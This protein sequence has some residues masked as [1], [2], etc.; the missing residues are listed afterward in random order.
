M[1]SKCFDEND[2]IV[3]TRELEMNFTSAMTYSIRPGWYYTL[4]DTENIP[5]KYINIKQRILNPDFVPSKK[6]CRKSGKGNDRQYQE[7]TLN[8][9][10]LCP[11]RFVEN[12]DTSRIPEK[13]LETECICKNPVNSRRK[14]NLICST[15]IE[16]ISVY[17]KVSENN[18]EP[19]YTRS[20]EPRS[21]ACVGSSLP[22]AQRKYITQTKMA[23]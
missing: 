17:R 18:G 9:L 13:I 14:D 1:A 22:R 20:W 21:V 11:W 3:R 15:V 23:L 2:D 19:V 6:I 16:Y 12:I 5:S 4:Q 10:A 8:N 7:S